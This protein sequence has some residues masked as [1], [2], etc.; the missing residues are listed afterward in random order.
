MCIRDRTSRPHT[1][2]S[3]PHTGRTHDPYGA[4]TAPKCLETLPL[5]DAFGRKTIIFLSIKH[6]RESNSHFFIYKTLVTATVTATTAVKRYNN[7][8]KWRELFPFPSNHERESTL[9]KGDSIKQL[10]LQ[11]QIRIRTQMQ[12]QLHLHT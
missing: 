8:K 3:R 4:H 1:E 7:K 9:E 11:M 2:T 5:G 12:L 6:E 10:Q